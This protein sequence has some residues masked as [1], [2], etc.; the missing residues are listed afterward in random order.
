MGNE[1][2]N[3]IAVQVVQ[4]NGKIGDCSPKLR[5]LSKCEKIR[6]DHLMLKNLPRTTTSSLTDNQR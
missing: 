6:E 4:W 1:I 5:V 2:V 3:S